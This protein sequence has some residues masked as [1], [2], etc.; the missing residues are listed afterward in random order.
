MERVDRLLF[1]ADG[2][3]RPQ[4]VAC[5]ASREEF[6]G[7]RL[8]DT[9]L[10]GTGVLRF[11]DEDVVEAAVKLVEHPLGGAETLAGK[12]ARRAR[13]QIL[14]VE[15][16]GSLLGGGIVVQ[17]RAGEAI[18]GGGGVDQ[19]KRVQ[20]L[21]ERRKTILGVGGDSYEVGPRTRGGRA[22]QR[23]ATLAL[24]GQEPL[25][26]KRAARLGFALSE[27][28]CKQVGAFAVCIAAR[29]ENVGDCAKFGVGEHG[30]AQCFESRLIVIDRK[31]EHSAEIRFSGRVIVAGLAVVE[32][33]RNFE[34]RALVHHLRQQHIKI[35]VG[36]IANDEAERP[37]ER[38]I[39]VAG[40]S[41]ERRL[42]RTRHD[43][44]GIGVVK[45]SEGRRYA[46][47]EREALQQP[48]GEGVDRLHLEPAGRFDGARKQRAR[49]RNVL[50]FRLAA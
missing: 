18:E 20:P 44:A 7:E 27:H 3:D 6:P 2:E 8:D 41:D 45:N 15:R 31:T 40:R 32:L 19:A 33:A 28:A 50:I 16:A 22:E 12:Q 9:P 37:A 25:G 39:F 4:R 47:F 11:V 21:R 43:F 36:G 38:G 30:G 29:P 34:P 35:G 23:L 26:K 10:G 13:D 46:G 48:F 24:S 1:V 49:V 42:D 14:E 17:R 5:A